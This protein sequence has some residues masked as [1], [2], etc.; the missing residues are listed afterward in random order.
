MLWIVGLC[1]APDACAQAAQAEGCLS[2]D[3]FVREDCP[4]C[5]EAKLFLA[6]LQARHPALQIRLHDVGR[7]PAERDRLLEL[8]AAHGVEQI[9][10][11]AFLA[12]G[13]LRVGFSASVTEAE[14]EALVEGRDGP[15]AEG[16]RLPIF[17]RIELERLGLPLFTFAIGFVDG[18]NPCAMWV[19][20]FLLSMLVH[21]HGRRRMLLIA[22]TF[23]GVSGLAYF[24]FMAAWLNAFLLVGYSRALQGTLGVVALGVGA[25]HIKDF[26]AF[27]RG[28]SLV[29]PERAKPGIYARVRRIVQA[30]N[31]AAALGAAFVLAI[32]VNSVEL[33]CT[34]AL[35]AVY[36]QILS[37]QGLSAGEYYAYLALYNAAYMLDDSVVLGVAVTTLGGGKLQERQGRWLKLLGGSVLVGLGLL[38]LL[39]PAAL[40]GR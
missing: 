25:I 3:V 30:E 16:V 38:L 36:T 10:V 7:D 31:L 5:A 27:G 15:L 1:W 18:L 2:F 20:A 29:I 37:T 28:I 21:V 17:G 24:A 26:F 14:L 23:V 19:L 35:P 22:G 9:G 32:L 39:A 11:P 13:N 40:S 33:L 8:A 4:H 6:R 34:A 12:C